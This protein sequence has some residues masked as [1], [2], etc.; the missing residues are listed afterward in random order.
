M[1]AECVFQLLSRSLYWT[2]KTRAKLHDA[3]LSRCPVST[4]NYM[5]P[6]PSQTPC[7]RPCAT[8]W[9]KETD[10]FLAPP[11]LPT[12]HSITMKTVN[13]C[14]TWAP[15]W[16]MIWST[17]SFFFFFF[18]IMQGLFSVS[19]L[20]RKVMQPSNTQNWNSIHCMPAELGWFLV[21][22]PVIAWEVS[23]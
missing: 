20:G 15:E 9:M 23:C 14:V 17:V 16:K 5:L 2:N 19:V 4:V 11:V 21:A 3:V 7:S 12:T 18:L 6:L 22:G 10:G 8:E 13:S 1:P